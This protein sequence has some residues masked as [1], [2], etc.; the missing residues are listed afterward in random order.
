MQESLKEKKAKKI[1]E[2]LLFVRKLTKMKVHTSI[3][4]EW[5][6][7]LNNPR[8]FY[9]KDKQ[10]YVGPGYTE[11]IKSSCFLQ[12]LGVLAVKYTVRIR[13]PSRKDLPPPTLGIDSRTINKILINREEVDLQQLFSCWKKDTSLPLS[14]EE[15]INIGEKALE[16]IE[17]KTALSFFEE[18]QNPQQTDDE[19]D[20]DGETTNPKEPHKKL[21]R[22]YERDPKLRA[23]AIEEYG[24][25]CVVCG[26]NFTEI[27]GEL[28][29]NFIEVHHLIPISKTQTE[30][31]YRNLRPVCSNCHRMLHRLYR[32]NEKS[33]GPHAIE[34]LRRLM[35][36]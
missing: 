35:K 1:L 10:G 24:L 4:G 14:E 30:T 29:E 15:L 7:D 33:I 25:G 16:I 21:T 13:C 18:L 5:E 31:S 22:Q 12:L 2:N 11:E 3:I 32:R 28:G 17:K 23:K 36:K 8:Y 6:I 27:Y 26:T 20:E 9:Q 19:S 34:E